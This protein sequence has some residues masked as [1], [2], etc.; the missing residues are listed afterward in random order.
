MQMKNK[1]KEKII[2]KAKRL[3]NAWSVNGY[4]AKGLFTWL[5]AR[6]GVIVNTR[7]THRDIHLNSSKA[8]S[9][10]LAMTDRPINDKWK[11]YYSEHPIGSLGRTVDD[12]LVNAIHTHSDTK[13][14]HSDTGGG[15]S[16]DD[17]G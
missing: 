8:I 9:I 2:H 10:W 5:F 16:N 7:P 15:T 13:A 1:I 4:T 3:T 14:R 12:C 11:E 6:P 17:E